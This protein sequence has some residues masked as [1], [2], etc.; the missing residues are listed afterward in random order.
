MPSRALL[1]HLQEARTLR[2]RLRQYGSSQGQCQELDVAGGA[3]PELREDVLQLLSP[4]GQ[5]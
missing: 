3:L 1:D 2:P 4:L 5:G